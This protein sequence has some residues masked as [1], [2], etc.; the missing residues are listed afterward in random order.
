MFSS[1]SFTTIHQATWTQDI[2][3]GPLLPYKAVR[4][5][6]IHAIREFSHGRTAGISPKHLCQCLTSTPPILPVLRVLEDDS[7]TLVSGI[8]ACIADTEGLTQSERITLG[9][10]HLPILT[11]HTNLKQKL[12]SRPN[13]NLYFRIS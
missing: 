1:K 5:I 12:R 13:K 4:T 11:I 9:K 8:R 2:P 6:R 3:A 7:E 10:R